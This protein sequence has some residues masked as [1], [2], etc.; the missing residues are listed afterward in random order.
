MKSIKDR[1]SIA[2][3][4]LITCSTQQAEAYESNWDIDFSYLFY[5]EADNRA[6]IHKAISN[7]SSELS[8]YDRTNVL[9]VLDTMSGSTPS[10]AVRSPTTTMTGASGIA[11][12]A[13]F[14]DTRMAV[15]LN[16]EHDINR[17]RSVNYGGNLSVEND[18]Q[19][20]GA[21]LAYN[22]DTE[23]RITTYTAEAAVSYNIIAK[24][25][26]GTPEPL[27]PTNID[28]VL[29]DGVRNSYE[30]L[31]GVS[32]VLNKK[33]IAQ[34]NYSFGYSDGYHS[35]PYKVISLVDLI[36]D[37]T[38]LNF[39]YEE[40]NRYYEGRPESRQKH[41]IFSSLVH[42]YGNR[43]EVI[44]LSY[45]YY[46]DNWDIDAHTI[47]IK[48]RKTVKSH[49]G[50]FVEPHV[51]LHKQSAASFFMHSLPND[52]SELPKYASADYRLDSMSSI[53]FGLTYGQRL[54]NGKLRTHIE[55]MTQNFD[56]A[57]HDTN[58]AL[59]FQVSFQ[60]LFD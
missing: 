4:T 33:S 32:R 38:N 25:S 28:S 51:R 8:D 12:M 57:E 27:S 11:D 60:N 19:S 21:S 43:D 10:G 18:F 24:R 52:G 55:Y 36:V 46:T 14:N 30:G 44:H 59:V 58:K 39:T 9:L 15:N 26:G 50:R 13:N 20:Y 6:T 17:L 48:H 1:L 40:A 3:C 31:V 35:D 47:D 5:S 29:S 16:W 34:I 54:F 56:Q 49:Q 2:A 41:T 22:Q 37:P 42:Q 7:I 23:D 45:R 53:S